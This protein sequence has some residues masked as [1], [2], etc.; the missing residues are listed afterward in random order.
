MGYLYNDMVCNKCINIFNKEKM[1]IVKQFNKELLT[2]KEL[3]EFMTLNG[4]SVNELAEILGVTPQAVMLWLSG[5]RTFNL[6]NSRIIRMF[7]K[8]PKMFQEFGYL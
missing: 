2:V 8:Y 6:T 4:L 7:I 5:S 1:M 3:K